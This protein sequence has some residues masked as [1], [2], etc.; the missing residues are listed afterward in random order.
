M[1]K[2]LVIFAITTFS[3][4]SVSG[5][6]NKTPHPEKQD[7]KQSQPSV[8]VTNGV[9]KQTCCCADQ[10]KPCS[11]SPTG[12]ASIERPHWW[13][14]SEWWLVLIAGLTGC[15]IGWQ[16]WETRKSAHAAKMSGDFMKNAERAW[17]IEKLEF[18]D[19][20][21]QIGKVA[22]NFQMAVGIIFENHGRTVANI[23]DAKLRFHTVPAFGDDLPEHPSYFPNEIYLVIGMGMVLLPSATYRIARE[24]EGGVALTEEQIKNIYDCTL[25]L[26]CYGRIEYLD[27]F[28]ESHFTQFCYLYDVPKRTNG[29]MPEGFIRIGPADYNVAT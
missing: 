17:V 24:F 21:P 28:K 6:P 20:L 11:N 5:Q 15:V 12:N 3:A 29:L 2:C 19:H 8:H 14:A 4:F 10:D 13:S 7:A 25:L 23:T 16:S 26:Y 27:A 18:S 22:S 9:D 1:L